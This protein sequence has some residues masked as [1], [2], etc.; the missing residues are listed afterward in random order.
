LTSADLP[1]KDGLA[2]AF[3][4]IAAASGLQIGAP[5]PVVPGRSASRPKDLNHRHRRGSRCQV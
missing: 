4:L 2:R 1:R 3:S 5:S